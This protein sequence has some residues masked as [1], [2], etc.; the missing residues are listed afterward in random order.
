MKYKKGLRTKNTTI[1]LPFGVSCLTSII[2]MTLAVSLLSSAAE[3]G[4]ISYS[5]V[6]PAFGGSPLNSTFLMSTADAQNKPK[7]KEQKRVEALSTDP[8]LQFTSTLQSRLLSAVSDKISD[9]IYGDK[10]ANSGTFIVNNTTV[11]FN[12]V[13]GNVVLSLSDGIRITN[14]TIPAN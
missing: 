6:N 2:G 5:P 9:A 8:M 3:A 10:P 11:S 14:I 7:K 12:R 1:A 4:D 13:G